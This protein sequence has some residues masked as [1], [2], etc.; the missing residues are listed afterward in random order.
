MFGV[1]IEVFGFYKVPAVLRREQAQGT[2]RSSW[3][4]KGLPAA[5]SI[6]PLR[7]SVAFV[8]P[9]AVQQ[10]ALLGIEC[11]SCRRRSRKRTL[12]AELSARYALGFLDA[13]TI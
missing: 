9:P 2:A 6:L 11:A 13:A 3:D 7:D 4:R 1:L 12:S 8:W 10:G 5:T